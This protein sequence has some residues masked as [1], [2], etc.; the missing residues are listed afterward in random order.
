MKKVLLITPK[1]NKP[2]LYHTD[3]LDTFNNLYDTFMYGPGF[4]YYRSS[5]SIQDIIKKSGMIPDIIVLGTA[6]ILYTLRISGLDRIDIPKIIFLNKEFQD[7]NMKLDFIKEHNMSL[8]STILNKNIYAEWEKKVGIPFIQTPHG[9]FI[10]KFKRSYTDRVYAF[11][12]AGA[13]FEGF[14][15]TH[16]RRAKQF[17]FEDTDLSSNYNILWRDEKSEEGLFYGDAY[18]EMLNN[19]TMFLSTLSPMG[20]IGLRFYELSAT[21]TLILCPKDEYDGVFVD[22]VNCVMYEDNAVDFKEKFEFYISSR[23]ERDKIVDQ[24]YKDIR[25][26][27]TWEQRITHL[28]EAI[29]NVWR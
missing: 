19:C 27:H 9:I 8:V 3:I 22:G 5:D 15:V 25:E 26:K 28:M 7:L 6:R 21:G 2:S 18:G 16:R 13:L 29:N 14:N 12:F 23:T 17:I 10:D 11:G 24:A 4:S 20:I 1:F